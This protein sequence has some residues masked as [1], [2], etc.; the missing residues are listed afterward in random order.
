MILL[1]CAVQA[2]LRFWSS[3]ADVEPLVTGVGPVEAAAAIAAALTARKYD[4]VVN[5]GIAGVFG[6][7]ARIGDG[8]V[9]STDTMAI[10]VE[11]GE[12]IVLPN[13][14]CTIETAHSDPALVASL[15]AAGFPALRGV[16]VARVTCTDAGA[17]ALAAKGAQ[18][19]TMEGFAALRAAARS[20]V[21]AIGIRGISN[22]CGDRTRSGWNFAAGMS[23]LERI[24][25]VFFERCAAM[26]AS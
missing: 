9:V 15:K 20:G 18:V 19:E 1:A 5:A 26:T 17:A 23:G 21:P 13:A 11:N 25:A 10:D 6:D 4:L 14:Q 22:R 12:P 16:T 24:A 7:A 3:R 8:I 2:E